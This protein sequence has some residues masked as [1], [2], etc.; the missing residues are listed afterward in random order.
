VVL[1]VVTS[2]AI[3]AGGLLLGVGVPQHAILAWPP[4]REGITMRSSP[5]SHRWFLGLANA[6]A[7]VTPLAA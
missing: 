4:V 2:P 7:S 5:L 1:F 3:K 6:A